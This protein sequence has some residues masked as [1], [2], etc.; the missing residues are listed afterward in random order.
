MYDRKRSGEFAKLLDSPRDFI[1]TIIAGSFVGLSILLA[2]VFL[3]VSA[4]YSA[5]ESQAD[6]SA[7]VLDRMTGNIYKCRSAD[8]GKAS[9]E[10]T[11]TGTVNKKP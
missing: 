9:C 1:A 5:F 2:A 10:T 11:V 8:Y 3:S 6:E 4:R 7:W